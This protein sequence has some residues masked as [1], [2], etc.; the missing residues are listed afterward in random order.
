[1]TNGA[2]CTRGRKGLGPGATQAAPRRA[3]QTAVVAVLQFGT[4]DV[5]TSP[6]R[7]PPHPYIRQR[8]CEGWV[9]PS[10]RNHLR[11]RVRPYVD[12]CGGGRFGIGSTAIGRE[13]S[14][15]TSYGDGRADPDREHARREPFSE[16]VVTTLATRPARYNHASSAGID[17][18][19][20]SVLTSTKLAT[21]SGL[22]AYR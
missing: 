4:C 6:H 21:C 3:R 20:T 14:R 15:A 17:S 13:A 2:A 18:T 5:A 9:H 16:I 8:I 19:E 10:I 22:L 12:F 1:M 11:R 7:V